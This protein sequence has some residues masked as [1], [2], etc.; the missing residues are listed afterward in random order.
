MQIGVSVPGVTLMPDAAESWA[1]E[2]TAEDMLRVAR[3]ADE[4]GFDFLGV[5]EH[6]IML[7][8]MVP[9]MGPRWPH[10]LVT[11]GVFAG[12]TRRIRLVNTVI[13]LGYHHPVELAKM[14]S[15]LDWLSGGRAI[16]GLGVGYLRREFAI[17][18]GDHTNRGEIANEMIEAMIELWSSDEPSYHGKHYEFERIAFEPRPVQKPYPPIWI[19]GHSGPSMRRTAAYGDGWQPWQ[20]TRDQLPEKLEYIRERRQSDGGRPF[21]VIMPLFEAKMDM[22]H[23]VLEPPKLTTDKDQI[24]AEIDALKQAGATGTTF[25]TP[26]TSSVDEY[27][28]RLEV[29]ASDIFPAIGK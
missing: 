17:M 15:T 6:A 14:I 23:T 22:R 27:I 11:L 10:P 16:V 8:R 5:P 29:F 4:L 3:K 21:D 24:L 1:A 12:A 20:I 28:E 19:G 26:P 2:A 9:V 18:G 25:A 13:V 7:E